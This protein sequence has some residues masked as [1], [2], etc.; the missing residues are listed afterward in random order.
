[1]PEIFTLKLGAIES[2]AVQVMAGELNTSPEQFLKEL[3]RDAAIRFVGGEP[4][5]LRRRTAKLPW[6]ETPA[7]KLVRKHTD[8]VRLIRRLGYRYKIYQD[9]DSIQYLRD[10]AAGEIHARMVGEKYRG[11]LRKMLLAEGHYDTENA[12]KD[13]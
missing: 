2:S 5:P 8:T 13:E 3:I 6:E 9:G 10:I 11:D 4:L 7:Y 1:M 12:R